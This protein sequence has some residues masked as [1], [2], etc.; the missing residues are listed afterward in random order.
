MPEP[1][2]PYAANYG[3]APTPPYQTAGYGYSYEWPPPIAAPVPTRRPRRAKRALVGIGAAAVAAGLVVSG[4]AIGDAT[5]SSGSVASSVSGGSTSSGS[6]DGSTGV[7]PG[8]GDGSSSG[9]DSGSS[10][11]SATG[12]ATTATSTQ[13]VG[14]VTIVSVLKYQN[15]ESAGTGMILTSDGKILTNN[16]VI[17][18]ATSVTVTV[19]STGKSYQAEVVGTDSTDDIAVLQLK[20]ASGLTTAKVGVASDVADVSTGDTVT[21]VGNAGGTGTL[22]AAT[23]KVTALD[24]TI[25]ATDES[26][27]NSETLDN[28]IQTDAAIISGDS[29]GPLYD[30]DGTIIGIDTA[31][32]SSSATSVNGAAVASQAYA[33]PITDALSIVKQIESGVETSS[34]RIGLPAFLGVGL[35]DAS[36]AGAA[37]GSVVSGGPADDAGIAAGSTITAVGGTSVTSASSLSTAMAKLEPGK[38]V[39]VSWADA[40]GTSHTATVTLTTGPAD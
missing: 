31:A 37:V 5:Q 27:A 19:E 38:R 13:Q 1:V 34:V 21:G 6:G 32:S 39:S 22:T 8:L 7:L 26:G 12:T 24:Q 14:I 15:A 29:G 17:D 23:G 40:A 9:S 16:H 3:Y 20:N 18:G 10:G 35:A 36:T 11:S 33:I 2:D 28:L 30:S 4:V 25:T